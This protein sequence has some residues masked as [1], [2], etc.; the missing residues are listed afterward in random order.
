M[1]ITWAY[2][3]LT[4]KLYLKTQRWPPQMPNGSF[5]IIKDTMSTTPNGSF[6]I[7]CI[8]D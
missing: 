7:K 1:N 8:K 6:P 2:R 3:K 4:W 5:P